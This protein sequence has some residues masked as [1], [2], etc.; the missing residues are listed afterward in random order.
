MN[1]IKFFN[2][3]EIPVEMHRAKVIQK[4][5]LLPIE[6]RKKYLKQ[7]GNNQFLLKNEA[8]FLD[9]LTDSGMNARSDKQVSA[10]M[11]ADDAYAGSRTYFELEEKIKEIFGFDFFLP[12]HQGRACEHLLAKGFVK[13]G[14]V[15]PTNYHFT[16]TRAHINLCGGKVEE[17]VFD[18][19][20][21]CDNDDPFKGN[22]DIEK[23][24]RLIDEVGSDRISFLRIETGTNLIGGQPISLGNIKRVSEICRRN[25]I[26][27]VMDASLLQ[28]NLYFIKVREEEC[29]D[30]SIREITKEI[31]SLIDIMYFSAR[32]LGFG[33]GGGICFKTAD[34][35]EKLKAMLTLHEGFLTYGGM[36]IREIASITQGLEETMDFDMISQGPRF[37]KYMVDELDKRNIPVVKPAG[38]L[39]C[40]IDARKF[41]A[42]IPDENYSAAS[43]T[44]AIYLASG[45]R[46]ME[47]GTASEERNPDGSEHFAAMELV[48]CAIP[49]RV[50][51]MSQIDYAID[52]IHWLYEN[53]NIIGGLKFTQEPEILR[54]FTGE[55]AP[56]SNWQD[57]LVA[58]F[59]ED[60]GDSL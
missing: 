10:A 2:G 43:L 8:I 29:K 59:K 50:F 9:M 4:L 57:K 24:Q 60:F 16:T 49:R 51:T 39:G 48:R 32:K 18:S 22:F 52:R 25:S 44:A 54:F 31:A 46:T 12:V 42:H 38:G 19:A 56:L 20:I 36:S 33:I 37:I 5:T 34:L 3:A 58:K 53:K 41:L 27:T 47:R 26:I 15:V 6:E 40:H 1:K 55:M 21:V 17:L 45:I 28:D 11:T 35:R 30:K 7:A 14:D 23:L 13:E